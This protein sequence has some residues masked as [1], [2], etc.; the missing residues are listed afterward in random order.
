MSET[1]KGLRLH[2][3]LFGRSNVGKSSLL[4][5]L[6]GQQASIVSA[7][8]GTTTDP[9]EK[10]LE[11]PPLGPVVFL[12]TAGLDDSGELGRLRTE[13]SLQ[14]MERAD[15]A[16]LVTE[17]TAWGPHEARIAAL[18]QERNI[19]FAVA[20]NK[21]D[22][23]ADAAHPCPAGAGD[24][25]G[26][27]DG[28]DAAVPVIDVSARSGLGLDAVRA[29]LAQ[30]APESALQQPPLLGD[31]LPEHGL[32]VLV[33]PIDT[34]APKGRLILPQVQAV[35]D[36]LDSRKL[37]MVVTEGDLPRALDSLKRAPD[38]VVCDSQVVRRVNADTPP[39][40]PLTTFSVLMAR[41]KGDL[42]ALARGAAALE[43]LRPGDAVR[44]QEACSHHPQKDD[45]ARVK[46]PRLLRR[47]AGGELRIALD[48]GKEFP[49]YA[50][51][52]RVV[53]HCGGCVITRGQM[54]ARLRAAEKAGCPMTNYGMAISLAQG[55]LERVLSPFPEAL[56]AFRETRAE[57]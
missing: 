34:G 27:P 23:P 6:T 3:A 49:R 31:L 53:V 24:A 54:L 57:G 18:L 52:C 16:L 20:R 38:L 22:A 1:P 39:H 32:L 35:R 26:S 33:T 55:V 13:R 2:I 41:L 7:A 21:M 30:L 46:L 51:D 47:L 40:I 11:L 17:K 45:I 29:A 42:P 28:P 25:P 36:S 37:C 19:P 10:T 4:N 15:V 56:R 50:A 44:I 43:R 48:A 9:V 14:I 8:P 5:A 12:D